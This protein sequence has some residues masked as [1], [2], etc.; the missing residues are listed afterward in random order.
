MLDMYAVRTVARMRLKLLCV[1][2]PYGNQHARNIAQP[3]CGNGSSRSVSAR[4]S[5]GGMFTR[6]AGD[7]KCTRVFMR[8]RAS[9]RFKAN[10]Y[11]LNNVLLNATIAIAAAAVAAAAAVVQRNGDNAATK[12]HI[13]YLEFNRDTTTV[14]GQMLR[15]YVTFV[16]QYITMMSE[17]SRDFPQ[18]R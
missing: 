2:A 5:A 10:K 1:T 18:E 11:G 12:V 4:N 17:G 15:A 3:G 16:P 6:V 7:V 9:V 13:L 14:S 8:P